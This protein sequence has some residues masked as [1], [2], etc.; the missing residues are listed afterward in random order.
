MTICHVAHRTSL[1]SVPQ[2]IGKHWYR[3]FPFWSFVS[4]CNFL[5]TP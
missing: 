4:F 2:M 3:L 1:Q 5:A